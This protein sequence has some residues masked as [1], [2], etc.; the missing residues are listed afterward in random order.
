MA[1]KFAELGFSVD[2][3]HKAMNHHLLDSEKQMELQ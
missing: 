1:E 2:D 3:M